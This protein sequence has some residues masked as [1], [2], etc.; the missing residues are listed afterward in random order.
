MQTIIF[1]NYFYHAPLKSV[2]PT[3]GY[4]GDP[5]V[6]VEDL[7]HVCVSHWKVDSDPL[8]ASSVQVENNLK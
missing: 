5:A 8:V 1:K 3:T 7:E 2:V 6:S 4:T